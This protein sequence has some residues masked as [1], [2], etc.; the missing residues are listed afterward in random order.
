[1]T[2]NGVSSPGA[3]TPTP[4]YILARLMAGSNW[5]PATQTCDEGS[6]FEQD[7]APPPNHP[8]S[9]TTTGL[10]IALSAVAAVALGLIA[11]VGVMYARMEKIWSQAQQVAQPKSSGDTVVGHPMTQDVATPNNPADT[12]KGTPNGNNDALVSVTGV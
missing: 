11:M 7:S 12:A 4:D 1:L 3:M 9:S 5:N 2:K 10:I 8:E 6:Q